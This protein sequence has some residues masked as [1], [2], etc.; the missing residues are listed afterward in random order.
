M[1]KEEKILVLV[2]FPESRS[3]ERTQLA[4]QDGMV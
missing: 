3:E 4:E 2:H 1:K